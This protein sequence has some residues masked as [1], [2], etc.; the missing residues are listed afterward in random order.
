M[1]PGYPVLTRPF[2]STPRLVGEG[3]TGRY[4]AMLGL[5]CFNP[6]P[7]WSAR[8]TQARPCDTSRSRRFNPPPAWSARGTR[9]SFVMTRWS[10]CFNPPPAWSARGTFA[11]EYEEPYQRVSIHPPLG[12][13]GELGRKHV[14]EFRH[15][16]SIH[17][18]LGR[19]GERRHRKVR[20]RRLSFNPPP[21][22][23]ARGTARC[24]ATTPTTGFQSTPRLVGEG[25]IIADGIIARS[26]DVSIHPPLGRRGEQLT[27]A[28]SMAVGVFQSTP[29]LVGEGNQGLIGV[30]PGST[31]FQSTPRLVGEG[32]WRPVAPICRLLSF[33]PPPAWSARGT[34]AR[35]SLRLPLSVSIHPPLG[36]RGERASKS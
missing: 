9:D 7:A 15:G 20:L 12:R 11:S 13:R 27:F 18:P 2:Q 32:N 23:S 24:T 21:A 36:R 10:R 17:P 19:R 31:G 1:R 4:D 29:R 26:I 3:N 35:F 14:A 6:P 25:N 30:M 34:V 28:L 8:G 33:N 22:W 5:W 16:V